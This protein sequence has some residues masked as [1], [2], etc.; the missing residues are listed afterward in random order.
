MI[1]FVSIANNLFSLYIVIG[2]GTCKHKKKSGKNR[3]PLNQIFSMP[4]VAWKG[5][6]LFISKNL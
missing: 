2:R 1:K 3:K 4:Y 6:I 5:G